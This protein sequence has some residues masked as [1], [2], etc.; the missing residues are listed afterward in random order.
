[1]PTEEADQGIV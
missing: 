1:M